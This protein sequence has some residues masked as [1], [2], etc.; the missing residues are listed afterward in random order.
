MHAYLCT[1]VNTFMNI[2]VY[3]STYVAYCANINTYM[4]ICVCGGNAF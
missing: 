3:T 2:F 1:Y 4:C